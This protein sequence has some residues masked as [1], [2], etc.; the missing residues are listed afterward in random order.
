MDSNEVKK[1]LVNDVTSP[2]VTKKTA[3]T[4]TPKQRK[5]ITVDN[6]EESDNNPLLPPAEPVSSQ[7]A[8]TAERVVKPL[9]TETPKDELPKTPAKTTD[10]AEMP[11]VNPLPETTEP[12]P[13]EAVPNDKSESKET[14]DTVAASYQA[15]DALP[16]NSQQAA[17][18]IKNTMQEPKIFDTTAYHIPIK[19]THHTH[20]SSKMAFTVGTLFALV[21]VSAAVY[22]LY[23]MGS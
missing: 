12:E 21:V 14:E 18:A 8:T 22:V 19:E 3:P 17:A 23:Q 16:D 6:A 1:R 13:A 11:E 7:K 20:G 15:T 4:V 5:I 2:A 9:T 10:A